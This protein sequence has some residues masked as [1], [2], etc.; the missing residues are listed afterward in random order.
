MLSRK[1]E[2]TAGK[3]NNRQKYHII[4]FCLLSIGKKPLRSIKMEKMKAIPDELKRRRQWCCWRTEVRDNKPTK[5][6]VSPQTGR[7]A[8]S[9]DSSTW[10]SFSTAV[11]Y[12]EEHRGELGGVGFMFSQDDPYTGIDLDDCLKNGELT[13]EAKRIVDKF[14]SYTEISPSGAGLHIIIKATKPGSRCRTGKVEIYDE[15]RY[16]TFTGNVIN[17]KDTIRERQQALNEFYDEVFSNQ[18][19]EIKQ[20]QTKPQQPTSLS[21]N[22][23]LK[24]ALNAKNGD[25]FRD[26]WRGDT[27]GYASHSEADLALCSMLAFWTGGDKTQIDTLFR[28]SGL[29]RD[30]W[31][32]D[33]YRE[34]TIDEAVKSQRAYDPQYQKANKTQQVET[35]DIDNELDQIPQD[36]DKM[37]LFVKVEALLRKALFAGKD[38][39]F[40]RAWI[41]HRLKTKFELLDTDRKNYQSMLTR[42]EKEYSEQKKEQ[43]RK[44]R[45]QG[46]QQRM[47]ELKEKDYSEYLKTK[48]HDARI[49]QYKAF[50]IKQ[51]VS[52]IVIKDL[53]EHGKFYKTKGNLYYYFN[54]ETLKL[55]NLS[56][57]AFT[58][59]VNHRYGVNRSETEFEYLIADLEAHTGYNGKLTEVFRF[60]H[61]DIDTGNLYID[62]NDHQMYKLNGE[63]IELKP[64]GTDGVLFITDDTAEP[65]ELVDIG[66]QTFIEPL[67]IEPINFVSDADVVLNKE[68]QQYLLNVW[69]YSIFF[70]E[71]LQTKPLQLFLGEKG[72]GKSTTQRII[73]KWLIG[74]DFDL[75]GI[76]EEDDFD[77]TVSNNYLCCFD[78]VDCY[79]KW[80]NDRLAQIA[81]GG[82]IE[83]RELYTTNKNAIYYPRVFV[84][85]NSRE[86]KF[87]RDDV[88]D[89]LLLFR[90]QRLKAFKSETELLKKVTNHRNE[91]WTELI[92]DLNSIVKALKEDNEP[93]TTSFRMADFAKLGW[94]ISK[95]NG[96]GDKWLALLDKMS[97]DKSE[98]LL[99]D[100]PIFN[101]LDNMLRENYDLTDLT[102]GEL[103]SFMKRYEKDNDKI[104]L[105]HIENAR[106]LGQRLSHML[107]ELR[108][109]FVIERE[110]IRGR[111]H[112]SIK[113][114]EDDDQND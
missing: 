87:K 104:Y 90:V 61:Y 42:L 86:P 114:K 47:D 32:R 19:L 57:I 113:L 48:I 43:E 67:I 45:Q 60:S 98:F 26:L 62:R 63:T 56:D 102:T 85:L 20:E 72:S 35:F 110:K 94:R 34:R 97:K 33:D 9:D 103:Y 7:N 37:D 27:S 106:S 55:V 31:D 14:N 83:L 29:M 89:R 6:P 46:R 50:E 59:Y 65:L 100:D 112:Y 76:K 73:G 69:I 111:W 96:A 70:E 64:N 107:N 74:K 92:H 44:K 75:Q 54:E 78:N 2:A 11:R 38:K 93:F 8:E 91:L 58:Q 13:P 53:C 17:G 109:Y 52:S 24:K 51:N 79:K 28:Q 82:K 101:C 5:I 15:L 4:F 30:K 21:V 88:V 36:I 80:L 84:T 81:T 12:Y 40:L 39:D 77:A 66:D 22:G 49:Q 10:S 99:L 3:R 71:L 18:A 108:V 68:E 25:K 41:D 16:F 23:L 95:V 105:G 1:A